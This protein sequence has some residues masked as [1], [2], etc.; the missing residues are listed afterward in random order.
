MVDLL[1]VDESVVESL[2]FLCVNLHALNH[3]VYQVV[4]NL[5]AVLV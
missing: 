2:E 4:V 1:S 5:L 3:S